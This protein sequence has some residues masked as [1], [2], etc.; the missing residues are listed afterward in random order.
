MII[1]NETDVEKLSDNELIEYAN[2]IVKE[3][4][5]ED[6]HNWYVLTPKT[7]SLIIRRL[8]IIIKKYRK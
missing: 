6:Y 1:I 3:V 2:K 7:K 4:D 8:L 5:R